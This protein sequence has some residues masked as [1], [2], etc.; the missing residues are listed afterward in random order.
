MEVCLSLP[1]VQTM[2][3]DTLFW[4]QLQELACLHGNL[5]FGNAEAWQFAG[6]LFPF[7]SPICSSSL[8]SCNSVIANMS[9]LVMLLHIWRQTLSFLFK[10]LLLPIWRMKKPDHKSSLHGRTSMLLSNA[11]PRS[12]SRVTA[13]ST[14]L[15][16]LK[17][18]QQQ[19]RMRSSG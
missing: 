16:T 9:L 10:C 4:T 14:S 2:P 17:V 19:E 5:L 15:A 11:A 12:T 18:K 1:D 3:G 6:E 7:R 13:V 8:M